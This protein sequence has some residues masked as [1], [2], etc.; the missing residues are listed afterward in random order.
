MMSIVA[1]PRS[2]RDERST[3]GNPNVRLGSEISCQVCGYAVRMGHALI[4]CKRHG[5]WLRVRIIEGWEEIDMVYYRIP[6]EYM[7]QQAEAWF[8]NHSPP[9]NE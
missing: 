1:N 6:Q 9:L 8:E 5:Y 7:L 3:T 4:F 2:G